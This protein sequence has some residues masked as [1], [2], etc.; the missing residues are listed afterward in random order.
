MDPDQENTSN[1]MAHER[2]GSMSLG[3][4]PA[5]A[6][7]ASPTQGDTTT[8]SAGPQAGAPQ[9]DPNAKIVQEVVN[10]EVSWDGYKRQL[11]GGRS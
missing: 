11:Y 4:A 5:V 8:A 6:D 7:D 3:A 10:S 2:N 9:V 1:T